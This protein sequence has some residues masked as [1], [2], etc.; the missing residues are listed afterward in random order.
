MQKLTRA[1][2]DIMQVLWD[3]KQGFLKDILEAIPEPRPKQSTVSTM[4]RIL[5]EKGFVDHETFGRTHRYFPKVT[6]EDYAEKYFRHFLSNY[7]DGSFS[8]LLSFFSKQ[9]DLNLRD[10]DALL[11]DEDPSST[12][13]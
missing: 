10:V 7:F 6:K 8:K 4:L 12:E 2:E 1:E 13:S 5:E 3:L 11:R 9:G